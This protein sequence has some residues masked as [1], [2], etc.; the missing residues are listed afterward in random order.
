MELTFYPTYKSIS[1]SADFIRE[2]YNVPEDINCKKEFELEFN[3]KFIYHGIRSD[4]P[5]ELIFNTEQNLTA[6]VLRWA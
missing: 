5:F 1:N 3:C 6:W 2:K 4:I